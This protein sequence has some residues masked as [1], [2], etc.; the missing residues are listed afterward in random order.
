M[1]EDGYLRV[2]ADWCE[3]AATITRM[4]LSWISRREAL[5]MRIKKESDWL[6]DSF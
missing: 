3:Y 4:E 1:D 2:H 6:S 5:R